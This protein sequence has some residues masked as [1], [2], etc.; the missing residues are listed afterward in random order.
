M[1]RYN[2]GSLLP[3]P[4]LN[5]LDDPGALSV[6]PARR[7]QLLEK[8]DDAN[9]GFLSDLFWALDTPGAIVRGGL[10]NGLEGAASA[11][12]QTADERVD[13]RE[14]LRQYGLADSED[15]WT[16]FLAGLGAE[17][18]LD[19]TALLSGS[20]RAL[21]SAGKA[22]DAAGLLYRA[23]QTLSK[24]FLAG[25]EIAPELQERAAS[26]ASRLGR[27]SLSATDVAGRPLVG[28]RAARKFG[29]LGDLV[30]NADDPLVAKQNVLDYLGG[31]EAAYES[32]Q[33]QTLGRDF[34]IGLPAADPLLTFNVPGGTA[35]G[36]AFDRVQ[37][38][39]R[40]SPVGRKVAQWTDN[41]VGQ[42]ADA[43]SQ[44]VFAGAD[45]ARRDAQ[46]EAR[47][48]ATYQ[49]AKLFE[50]T[51]DAFSEEGNRRLGRLI[52]QPI[53]EY[54]TSPDR[55]GSRGPLGQEDSLW[56]SQNPSV[57]AYLD[58]WDQ[59]A[60]D[61]PE[62]FA[63][64]GL[65][66]ATFDDPN[67]SGYLPRRVG[68]ML[69]TAARKDAS[70]GRVLKTLTGDQMRRSADMMVPGGRDT[71]AFELSRDPFI[72]GAKRAANTDQEAAKYIADK[73]FGSPPSTGGAA[74]VAEYSPAEMS[75]ATSLA[76][77]L[78]RLPDS[79]TKDGG[80]PLFGQHPTQSILQ[81]LEGRAG[82]KATA[83]AIYDSLAGSAALT[84][85][86][87]VRGGRHISVSEAMTRLGLRTTADEAGELGARAQMRTRLANRIDASP[88]SI[89]L[90]KVSVPEDQVE[91]LL[92]VREG[93]TSP[94]AAKE[95]TGLLD[96]QNELWKI[97]ILAWPTRIVR[98][99]ISGAYSNWLEGA[100]DTGSMSAAKALTT[101]SAFSREFAEALAQM[102]RY[103]RLDEAERAA[104]FYADLAAG[105][106]LDG[107]YLADKSSAIAGSGT[108][109]MLVGV[110]PERFLFGEGAAIRELGGGTYNPLS[111]DFWDMDKNPLARA[112]ARGGALSDKIN[113]L[114]GY[115]SLLKK[116]VAPEEAAR[117]MKRA[118]VDYSSLTPQERYI[119][120]KIFPFYAYTS[121]IFREALRQMAERPGGK[122]AQGLRAYERLQDSGDNQYVPPELRRQF[123]VPID[124]NDPTF[125]F[126]ADQGG[127]STTYLTGIADLPGYSALQLIGND[128][129]DTAGNI[130]MQANPLLR[131]GYEFLTG[132]DMFTRTPINSVSRSYGPIG[133]G[134]RAALQ[135]PDAGSGRIVTAADKL[136]D[137]VPFASRPARFA[138][139]VYDQDAGTQFPSRLAAALFSQSGVGKL[140]D[141]P[142]ARIREGI[143][144][145]LEEMASPFTR[146]ISTPYI[147]EPLRP[148]VPLEAQEALALARQLRSEG[149]EARRRSARLL[150]PLD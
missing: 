90:A 125:G 96:K 110:R 111:K 74:G 39:L 139:Q 24:A 56:E 131:T 14:L 124:P 117:R 138:A 92:R 65:R 67:I 62:E 36:D 6:S 5:P 118:H 1:S 121:R 130:A 22:A 72:A 63:E 88:D 89:E 79:V 48:E 60:K 27:P 4:D 64:V 23:P 82:A 101:E 144:D 54:G 98:D 49:A 15:T 119:R 76:R 28:T 43:E 13:G 40:W 7:R 66:G 25:K 145:R 42:A 120:D 80:V 19:P 3:L 146:D 46:S 44:M 148:S 32:L 132:Q 61:L 53:T 115:I 127:N 94:Q 108:L 128:A 20:S 126:L 69:Q 26:Y 95:L 102:P 116:G 16:N 51:S 11:L 149:R 137:L 55:I 35:L 58:W 136:L 78:H 75:Q 100:L 106:I 134:I 9:G 59:S 47:R 30:D 77:L 10:A 85:A 114:T 142:G 87:V 73:L 52:E 41:A 112:G 84:P 31:D 83:E 86:E 135:D 57:R 68:G 103:A 150:N 18:A 107:S 123:A 17:M 45:Q 70:L 97:G 33:G 8:A 113:R 91:R 105:G 143:T 21:T 133:K 109:D 99:L 2:A 141:V 37:D 29:T 147:P 34:G 122:Y 104:R 12:T 71:I 38:V 81:Y 93:Y 129:G 140:R 50:G